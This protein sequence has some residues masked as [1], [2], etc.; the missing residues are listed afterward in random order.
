MNLQPEYIGAIATILSPIITG[1]FGIIIVFIEYQL[2]KNL[3]KNENQQPAAVQPKYTPNNRRVWAR[4]L[5]FI[6]TLTFI[7]GFGG[8]VFGSKLANKAGTM[9]SSLSE[10]L[11][12]KLLSGPTPTIIPIGKLLMEINFAFENEG[13]CNNYNKKKL[14]YEE[15]R[16]YI[17]PGQTGFIAVCHENDDLLP[18]GSL[19]VNAFPEQDS[20][21]FGYGVLFGWKKGTVVETS[22]SCIFGIRRNGP[23]TEAVFVD[24]VDGQYN[25]KQQ[26]LPWLT[27]DNQPHTLLVTITADGFAQ[28]SVDGRYFAEHQFSKCSQ[29][30]IGMVAWGIPDKKIYYDDLKLYHLP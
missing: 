29:G 11:P 22:D 28:G 21:N 17:Y 2:H 14:G 26:E 7:G 25:S 24:W 10:P 23:I 3:Y 16:Y 27:L 4:R 12:P 30:P 15:K 6:V 8:C 19:Q 20:D 13:N 18:Q 9:A 5:W 1:F